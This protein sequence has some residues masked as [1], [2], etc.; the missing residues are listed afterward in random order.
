MGNKSIC[1][2]SSILFFNQNIFIRH[3]HCLCIYLFGPTQKLLVSLSPWVQRDSTEIKALAFQVASHLLW[4]L[5]EWFLSAEPV[6]RTV[7]WGWQNKTRQKLLYHMLFFFSSPTC[8]LQSTVVHR[9]LTCVNTKVPAWA[10]FSV[11][12]GIHISEIWSY[13]LSLS[14]LKKFSFS[15]P[16]YWSI[17]FSSLI[18]FSIIKVFNG[19]LLWTAVMWEFHQKNEIKIE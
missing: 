2:I 3:P 13:F 10:L 7:R 8:H 9:R 4:N 6:V 17:K 15:N 14:F 18:M 16:S 11:L 12:A 19:M 1:L 5:V